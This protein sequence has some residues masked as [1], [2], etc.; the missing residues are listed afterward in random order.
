MT[1][2]EKEGN[3]TL[4]FQDAPLLLEGML[5]EDSTGQ[6][7]NILFFDLLLEKG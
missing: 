3:I 1:D 7:T 2:E 6:K 5:I 4:V